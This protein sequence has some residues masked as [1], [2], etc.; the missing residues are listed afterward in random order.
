MAGIVSIKTSAPDYARVMQKYGAA[1]GKT[2][3]EVVNRAAAQANFR[4]AAPEARGGVPRAKLGKFPLNAAADPSKGGN[5][6]KNRFYFAEQSSLGVKKGAGGDVVLRPKAYASFKKR[7]AAKGAIAAGFLESARKL[8]LKKQGAASLRR[9][10][11]GSASKSAGTKATTRLK[12]VSV[13]AVEGSYEVG[14]RVMDRAILATIRDMDEFANKLL[15]EIN[16][17]FQGR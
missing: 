7:R 10:P 8:G 3:V 17:K 16:D 12:A 9:K 14:K 1:R 13:N 5:S 4:C 15:Q 11:G 6:F 2:H